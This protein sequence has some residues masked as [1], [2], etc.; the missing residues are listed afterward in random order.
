MCVDCV[1]KI[2]SWYADVSYA[3]E[4]HQASVQYAKSNNGEVITVAD[5]SMERILVCNPSPSN[6]M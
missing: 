2:G 5:R 6:R 4:V 3:S 1:K